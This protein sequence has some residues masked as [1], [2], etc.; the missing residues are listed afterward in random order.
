M[1]ALV[2]M[3]EMLYDSDELRQS[4]N[5]DA[6]DQDRHWLEVRSPEATAQRE[7]VAAVLS[8]LEYRLGYDGRLLR[9][10]ERI[11]QVCIEFIK[12]NVMR[13]TTAQVREVSGLSQLHI[14]QRNLLAYVTIPSREH[15][16]LTNFESMFENENISPL[17]VFV[18]LRQLSEL[19]PSLVACALRERQM[20]TASA[21]DDDTNTTTT[22]AT[23]GGEEEDTA[24]S[25]YIQNSLTFS[26][27]FCKHVLD[28]HD[29]EGNDTSAKEL[30]LAKYVYKTCCLN[31]STT[32]IYDN[33]IPNKMVV[34]FNYHLSGFRLARLLSRLRVNTNTY[35]NV[36]V[37][38]VHLETSAAKLTDLINNF[39]ALPQACVLLLPIKRCQ[40]ALNIHAANHMVFL[41]PELNPA[42]MSQATKR[43]DRL[44]SIHR[45]LYITMLHVPGTV[46]GWIR[47]TIFNPKSTT[48]KMIDT[49]A[50]GAQTGSSDY[51]CDANRVTIR[52]LIGDDESTSR[53]NFMTEVK[54]FSSR[55]VEQHATRTARNDAARRTSPT[56]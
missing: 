29:Q 14:I 10:H 17:S 36:P 51:V 12:H 45:E 19:N 25:P 18:L 6:F 27:A 54:L 4:S 28:V 23:T 37:F 11:H 46:N 42:T 30:A 22:A 32:D 3:A 9:K 52:S 50:I 20:R 35:V 39:T 21:D 15:D 5:D 56:A 26:S 7:I 55:R 41:S 1:D 53:V 38:H 8:H 49:H 16:Y 24:V 43:A 40:R 48:S 47:D 13:R 33:P 2:H 44:S 31:P 34:F